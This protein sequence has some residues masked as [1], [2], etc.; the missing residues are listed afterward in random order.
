MDFVPPASPR[1]AVSKMSAIL[2]SGDAQTNRKTSPGN[3]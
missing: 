2:A 1:R 3:G